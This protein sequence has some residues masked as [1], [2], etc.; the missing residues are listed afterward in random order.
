MQSI[1]LDHSSGTLK[2]DFPTDYNVGS[3]VGADATGE[4]MMT[5]TA[6]KNVKIKVNHLLRSQGEAKVDY[7][8]VDFLFETASLVQNTYFV[9]NP[10]ITESKAVKTFQ[11]P[12]GWTRSP[13][14]KPAWENDDSRTCGSADTY[15]G[16]SDTL[17]FCDWP[18][19][20]QPEKKGCVDYVQSVCCEPPDVS[21]AICE[22]ASDYQPQHTSDFEKLSSSSQYVVCPCSESQ[23]SCAKIASTLFDFETPK[24]V[25]TITIEGVEFHYKDVVLWMGRNGCCGDAMKTACGAV[26][27]FECSSGSSK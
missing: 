18:C 10:T 17:C 2:I 1:Q 12:N 6:G 7:I 5:L 23:K 20:D 21:A 9:Y 8:F 25:G 11:C 26:P 24:C 19:A 16:L 3:T 4:K 13:D 22:S 27:T 15:I 14:D